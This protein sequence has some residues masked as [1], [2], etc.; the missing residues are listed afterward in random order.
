MMTD[1]RCRRLWFNSDISWTRP[2]WML[3]VNFAMCLMMSLCFSGCICSSFLIT[4]TD[5]A[6]TNSARQDKEVLVNNI[7]LSMIELKLEC[8]WLLLLWQWEFLGGKRVGG[9]GC[10][11]LTE[12][13]MTGT[14]RVAVKLMYFD[15]PSSQKRIFWQPVSPPG[16]VPVCPMAATPPSV[17]YCCGCEGG[18]IV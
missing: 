10:D 1:A 4:T 5:S 11:C 6:T 7:F 17:T 15:R 18:Y 8:R 9:Y 16:F 2:T 3:S 12:T 14:Q 13:C